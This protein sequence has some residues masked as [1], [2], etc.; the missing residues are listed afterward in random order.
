MVSCL[1]PTTGKFRLGEFWY[2]TGVLGAAFVLDLVRAGRAE[3]D[4]DSA[5]AVV[6]LSG[7]EAV[8]D[9][10]LR[11]GVDLLWAEKQRHPSAALTARRATAVL[12]ARDEVADR[13]VAVG[14]FEA[15]ERKWFGVFGSRRYAALDA[16]RRDD[17]V[18]R[19]SRVV[20]GSEEPDGRTGP[21][22]A[23]LMAGHALRPHVVPGVRRPNRAARTALSRP[24][25]VDA[26]IATVLQALHDDLRGG[27]T[28]SGPSFID[29]V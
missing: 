8:D 20:A 4:G 10:A 23:L 3:V 28:S 1:D 19:L 5:R 13:L 21:L 9:P 6:Q 7:P 29:A 14:L 22:I 18:R 15:H 25:W 26:K 2:E 16:A 27:H 24:G 11:L 12:G 17:L